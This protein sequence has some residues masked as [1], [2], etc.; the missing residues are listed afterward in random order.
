MNY[1][2]DYR[3][4]S[5]ISSNISEKYTINGIPIELQSLSGGSKLRV[6][7]NKLLGQYMFK[8]YL[9]TGG[10]I[11]NKSLII[12]NYID[13]LKDNIKGIES[14]KNQIENKKNP[15]EKEKELLKK[16][17]NEY[18][19][20]LRELDN[21]KFFKKE[22][23]ISVFSERIK[24]ENYKD[25]LSEIINN[26]KIVNNNISDYLITYI[27]KNEIEVKFK[28]TNF[29]ETNNDKYLLLPII[30][31]K[32]IISI[33]TFN[34]INNNIKQFMY[35]ITVIDKEILI[36]IFN[37]LKNNN[38]NILSEFGSNINIKL[39][40]NLISFYIKFLEK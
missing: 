23:S 34:K 33:I 18:N 8:K 40:S 26:K 17:S 29:D 32:K 15:N 5:K 39:T 37:K 24:T 9:Q 10:S 7:S 22:I 1:T 30:K 6:K 12:N 14:I 36:N 27:N 21:Y 35:T 13:L 11:I 3:L 16:V 20:I 4:P 19:Y 38:N 28:N 25:I 2:N 31:D